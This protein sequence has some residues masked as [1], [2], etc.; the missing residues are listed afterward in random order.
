M[1]MYLRILIYSTYENRIVD[2]VKRLN[3]YL[4]FQLGFLFGFLGFICRKIF[5]AL[6]IYTE[7]IR[8]NLSGLPWIK[9]MCCITRVWFRFFPH[10]FLDTLLVMYLVYLNVRFIFLII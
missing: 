9:G 2:I 3:N 10:L 1:E 5:S 4:Y 7:V 6:E 8:I